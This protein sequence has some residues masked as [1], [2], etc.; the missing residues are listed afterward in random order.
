ME[1]IFLVVAAAWT[2]QFVLSFWQLRRFHRQLADLRKLGRCAV[3]MAGNRWQGRTYGVLVIDEHERVSDAAL[4]SGWTIFSKLRPVVGLA[5]T[6]LDAIL[7]TD[8]PVGALR[9]SQWLALQHA[10][11]F[12]RTHPG[13]SPHP[14]STALTKQQS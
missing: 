13:S 4:F 9:R 10:G 14:S 5:G 3:G 8:T 12:F 7:T 6:R 2:L 11:Q 1:Y